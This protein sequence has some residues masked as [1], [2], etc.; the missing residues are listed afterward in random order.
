[1]N[2][3]YVVSVV[4]TKTIGLHVAIAN[5]L[6]IEH[7]TDRDAADHQARFKALQKHPKYCI[8]SVSVIRVKSYMD[9]VLNWLKNIWHRL[10]QTI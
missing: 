6:T 7:A 8:N 10:K 2:R 1:M 4:M 3:K 9:A 5:C